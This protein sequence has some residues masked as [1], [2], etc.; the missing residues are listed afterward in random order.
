MSGGYLASDI[1]SLLVVPVIGGLEHILHAQLPL[2]VLRG[3][4]HTNFE[5]VCLRQREV[6]LWHRVMRSYH[7]GFHLG[8]LEGLL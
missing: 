2:R 4:G 1:I 6:I 3:V 8:L 5:E 7:S